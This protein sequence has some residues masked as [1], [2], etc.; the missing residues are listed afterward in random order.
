MV[1][2]N[3]SCDSSHYIRYDEFLKN[4]MEFWF[5]ALGA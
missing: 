4:G 2:L 3:F 5:G 1:A